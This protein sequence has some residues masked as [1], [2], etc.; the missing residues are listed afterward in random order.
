MCHSAAKAISFQL[1]REA[2]N[3]VRKSRR[4]VEKILQEKK[5]VYGITTGI[6]NFAKVNIPK[7]KLEYVY[8]YAIEIGT[9]RINKPYRI[10]PRFIALFGFSAWN[11]NF[12]LAEKQD[13]LG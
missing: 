10:V 2:E 3:N 8:K 1:S 11:L 4:L 9:Y 7:D 13:C 6:G 5:V 12:G